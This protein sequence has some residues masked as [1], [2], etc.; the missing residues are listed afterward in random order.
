M[1][2]Q[3]RVRLPHTDLT[4]GRIGLASSFGVAPEGLELAFDHGINFFYWGSIRR[5]GFGQGVR[6]LARRDREKIVVAVQSYARWPAAFMRS[7]VD[8]ALRRLGLDYAD[9]LILGWYNERPPQW[10]LDTALELREKGRVRSIMISS[11]N[12]S[13]FPEIAKEDLIDLLMVRYNAAHRGA[14]KD[15]FPALPQGE[16]H[17]GICAYTATRWGSLLDSKRTPQNEPVPRASHCYRFC[18][19]NPEVDLVFCGPANLDQVREAISALEK[20]P[21]DSGEL[22]WMK[23]VGDHVYGQARFRS[24]TD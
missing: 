21:L 7:S 10:I 3:S 2:F 20:G 15:V 16:T 12:R 11:H 19:T 17:P 1:S 5:P 13:F 24:L 18:L 4:V 22:A 9:V 6:N 8:L 23:R 14:E